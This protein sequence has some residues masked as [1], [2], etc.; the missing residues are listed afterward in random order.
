M[1]LFIIIPIPIAFA[2]LEHSSVGGQLIGKYHVMI[3]L[4][5]QNPI[6]EKE[7]KIIFSI[8]D[9]D[10]NDIHD[11]QTIVEIYENSLEKRIF[12]DS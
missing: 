10:G 5:P 12:V 6:P 7:S 3:G 8:Q 1:I 4:D 11:I 2:H 9:L